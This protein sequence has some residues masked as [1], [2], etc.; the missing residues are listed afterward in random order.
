[1]AKNEVRIRITGDTAGLR[2]AA[3]DASGLLGGLGGKAKVAGAAVAA[4]MAVAGAAAVGVG[5]KLYDLGSSFDNASDTIR[6]GTGATGQALKDLEGSFG[7]VVSSVPTD[8]A[9]ASTAIADLNTYLGISGD[10]LE[11]VSAS[12]LEMTRM[13]GGDLST[14]IES[15]SRVFGDWSVTAEEM[16]GALDKIWRA[17]QNTGIGL[18]DL[19]DQM[20]KY[21]APMRQL[22]FSFDEAAAL[23]GKF[24]KEGVNGELVI[25]SMRI[26]LGKMAREGEPAIETFKRVTGEIASAGDASKANALALELFG[27][28]AGPDMAAAIRE[29]RFEVGSL[30]DT[31]ANGSET[32]AAAG[33][34]TQDF[35]EKWTLFK[36][37]TLLKLEP[38]ASKVFDG[39][40]NTFT[41]LEPSI[42]RLIDRGGELAAEWGPR[43]ADAF[44]RFGAG[45]RD[46]VDR[47][48]ALWAEWGPRVS[49]TFRTV[50]EWIER[51]RALFGSFA[52]DAGEKGSWLSTTL[53]QI[54]ELFLTTFGAIGAV[55]ARAVDVGTFLWQHFG[56]LIVT[57]TMN[58][59]GALGRIFGGLLDMLTGIF[60][61]IKNVL[62]GQ[63]GAAW[64]SIKQ[65]LSGAWAVIGGLLSAGWSMIRSMFVAGGRLLGMAWL[66]VW[67]GVKWVAGAAW[68]WVKAKVSGVVDWLRG[69]PGRLSGAFSGMW[70]GLK[71]SF[72]SAI[73]WVVDKWNGLSFT[74]PTVDTP[75]GSFGG[76]SIDF[77]DIPRLADGGVV[78]ARP[79]GTL[80]VIGEG[81][82]DEAVIPLDR[83]RSPVATAST[84][85]TV[86]VTAGVGDPAEIGRQVAAT[87]DAYVRQG[88]RVSVA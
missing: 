43:L 3:S 50:G 88:G 39:L 74:I 29:G 77:P 85:I 10:Q 47:G 53:G 16:P 54:G 11:N 56:D 35:G 79:G 36:N 72:R 64:D 2:G 37:R 66:A 60:G 68:D 5:K 71:N 69:V 84:S 61:L 45:V 20:V 49:E 87:L 70:D 30:V 25:G 76:W 17:S 15:T 44:T 13:A 12:V 34:D 80:A 21:G 83:Y 1:M 73:N 22:G 24:H 63:W 9:S 4:G 57:H 26:A 48:R 7:D 51:G 42:N 19:Q 28:R 18:S 40:G 14:A 6:I 27:A 31:I 23:I 75:L 55:I 8:F 33:A 67:N 52:R 81:G 86:N 32:I 78:K 62:T 46:V 58:V 41:R 82:R 38:I 59:V 65:I